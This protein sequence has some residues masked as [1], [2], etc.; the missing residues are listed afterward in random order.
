[1]LTLLISGLIEIILFYV[2]V[3]TL[4]TDDTLQFVASSFGFAGVIGLIYSLYRWY[5]TGKGFEM[6]ELYGGL[7]LGLPN[8]MTIYLLGYLLSKG[9][10]ASVLFPVNSVSILI[11]TSLV[12]F[13]IYKERAD[14]G[15]VIGVVIGVVSII[16]MSLA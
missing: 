14:S 1:M 8:F 7:V 16:L 3:E 9:W 5:T 11:L 6:K 12:G 15:K 4:V 13:L 2:Q 10:E